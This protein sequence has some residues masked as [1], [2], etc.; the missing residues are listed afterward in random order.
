MIGRY[1]HKYIYKVETKS[2][3]VVNEHECNVKVTGT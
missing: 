1:N 3:L 2:L